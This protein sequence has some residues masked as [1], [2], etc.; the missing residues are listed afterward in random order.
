MSTFVL[1]EIEEH[2]FPTLGRTF[3]DEILDGFLNELSTVVRVR[4][5]H[6]SG[7][8]V[9]LP[10]SLPASTLKTRIVERRLNIDVG[11]KD[12]HMY[13]RKR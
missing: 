6:K 10:P 12:G 13:L 4:I 9:H 1:E 7:T 2:E 11:I 5:Y 3:A 8:E